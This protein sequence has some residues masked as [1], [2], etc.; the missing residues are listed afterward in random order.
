M[1]KRRRGRP[2]KDNNFVTH[3]SLR[4]TEAEKKILNEAAK[5]KKISQAAM[6]RLW[7]NS[8]NSNSIKK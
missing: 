3:I 8:L 2:K 6:F 1:E 7:L 4:C 5:E